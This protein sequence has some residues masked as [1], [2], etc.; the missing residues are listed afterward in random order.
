M[1]LGMAL[2]LL[3]KNIQHKTKPP[4]AFFYY[5]QTFA[6]TLFPLLAGALVSTKDN[7]KPIL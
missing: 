5:L 4:F 2:L 6:A 1:P 3:I 7:N